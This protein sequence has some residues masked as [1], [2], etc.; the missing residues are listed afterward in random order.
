MQT[1]PLRGDIIL[2]GGSDALDHLVQHH[3][4]PIQH[5]LAGVDARQ[6]EQV[7][8]DLRLARRRRRNGLRSLGH[9]RRIARL[10]QAH[11]QLCVHVDDVQRVLEF[12]RHH[13]EKLILLRIRLFQPVAHRSL[14][15]E[16]RIA[17]PVLQ[18]R[19]SEVARDLGVAGQAPVD[20]RRH[21]PA[22]R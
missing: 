22:G 16:R 9:H 15:A 21:A 12:M 2:D 17:V 10:G 7:V 11:Q 6:I 1:Q 14:L 19:L 8:D 18:L 4:H 20:Q 13:R 3:L 5:D